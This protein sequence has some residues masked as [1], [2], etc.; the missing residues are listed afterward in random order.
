MSAV[1]G[2]ALVVVGTGGIFM[3]LPSILFPWTIR[4]PSP[5]GGGR[6]LDT[7]ELHY[8]F[9]IS[10]SQCPTN[11]LL[12]AMFLRG[13]SEEFL[14]YLDATFKLKKQINKYIDVLEPH[15]QKV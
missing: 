3:L 10:N 9:K 4:V 2:H 12:T 6:K 14:V 7:T 13:I 11:V 1:A 15:F 5:G 8:Q